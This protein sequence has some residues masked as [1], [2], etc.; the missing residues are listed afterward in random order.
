[1]VNNDLRRVP[2]VRADLDQHIADC[3]ERYERILETMES[4]ND[5][6]ERMEYILLEIRNKLPMAAP[7]MVSAHK[8]LPR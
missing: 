7:R 1:M 2:S 4:V 3:D 8:L 5:R 6:L